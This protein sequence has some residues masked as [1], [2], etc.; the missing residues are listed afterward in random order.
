MVKRYSFG[1]EWG[2]LARD[3]AE[4][5]EYVAYDDYAKLE[6][7]IEAAPHDHFC[8]WNVPFSAGECDCW[9]SKIGSK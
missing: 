5:G 4:D 6:S 7:I 3:T 2:Y 8:L 1:S 9:K